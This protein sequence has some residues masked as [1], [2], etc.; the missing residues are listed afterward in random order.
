ML[1]QIDTVVPGLLG[2]RSLAPVI[3]LAFQQR[4]PAVYTIGGAAATWES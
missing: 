2:T 3:A 4:L 1:V